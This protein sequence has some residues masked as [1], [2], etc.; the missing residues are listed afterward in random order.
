MYSEDNNSVDWFLVFTKAK[1]DHWI[2]NIVD[3][4]MG[5]VYAVK[6]LN[7]YQWL[8]VQ[9]RTNLTEVKIM[10]KSQYPHIRMIAGPD[11]KVINVSARCSLKN[12]GFLNWFNCVEQVKALIGIRSFWVFTPKQLYNLLL[13]HT[14]E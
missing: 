6:S 4:D 5:H 2:Y 10:L 12:R 7:D 14:D 11:D 3:R 1:I 9:P 8:I 13:R